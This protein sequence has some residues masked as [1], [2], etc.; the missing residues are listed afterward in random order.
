MTTLPTTIF[1]Q[2]Y[3][4][5]NPIDPPKQSKTPEGPLGHANLENQAIFGQSEAA[6]AAPESPTVALDAK[7]A[8]YGAVTL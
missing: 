2:N 7:M 5:L 8:I 6:T 3:F 1:Q 4:A